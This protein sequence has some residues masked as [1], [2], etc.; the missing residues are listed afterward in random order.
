MSAA[1]AH[2]TAIAFAPRPAG[3]DAERAA[4]EYCA[5]VLGSIGCKV[6]EHPFDYSAF[7]G[8]WGTP[9]AGVLTAILFLASGHL[10]AHGRARAALGVL[11]AGAA[12][13]GLCAWWLGRWGV[14][15]LPFGRAS[16]TNL[17]ATR[18]A[19]AMWLV[20]HLD[21]K[22][23]PIPIGVRAAAITACIALWLAATVL[24]IV[25]RFAGAPEQ[26]WYLMTGLG[27][28]A[29]L[30]VIASVVGARSAGALDDAS[31]VVTVLRTAELMPAH[32]SIGVLLTSAEE[33]GL[34]GARAWA[35]EAARASAINIDG[36]DDS[37]GIRLLYS[38]RKPR[39]LL[40]QLGAGWESASRLPPGLLMDGVALADAGWHVVNVSR[41]SWRTVS[42]IHTPRDD[43]SH[44]DG[45]GIE[46]VAAMLAASMAAHTSVEQEFQ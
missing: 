13:L 1:R 28:L 9:I 35:R 32:V 41:G 14:L 12:V 43:L 38:G 31:G 42:R 46:E 29:A 5:G 19:P 15:D 23:Q 30:P 44:L 22:S 8:R 20:A 36:I 24:S 45:S 37:G 6:T 27:V 40:G 26:L 21:S 7:P 2:L 39:A 10:G 3:G 17:V 34:A 25:Q 18:G 33:L 4:R 16:G 11:L